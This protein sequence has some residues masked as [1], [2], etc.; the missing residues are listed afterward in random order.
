MDKRIFLISFIICLII[1]LVHIKIVGSVV[2]GDGRYYYSIAKSLAFDQ[3]FNFE[4]EFELF[5]INEWT[6]NTGLL[7]NK[8][9][10]GP[11]LILLPFLFVTGVFH[12]ALETTFTCNQLGELQIYQIFSGIINIVVVFA[13]L[14]FLYCTLAKYYSSK[15]ARSATLFTLFATNLFFYTSF[16]PVNSHAA[17]FF[18]A[19]VLFF[20][21][22]TQKQNLIKWLFAGISLGW[23]A[24]SR[25]IDGLLIIPAVYFFMQEN[26]RMRKGIL[27]TT[28]FV[29]IF[30]IQI[31]FWL[32]IYGTFLSPYLD[33]N[34]G[35]S[36][37]NPQLSRLLLNQNTGL[38]LWTPFVFLGFL[39]LFK[40]K[41]KFIKIFI[42]TILIMFYFISSWS[43]WDQGGSFGIRMLI[44]C[45][46]MIS[47]G[48]AEIFKR[49]KWKKY[50]NLNPHQVIFVS[51][52]VNIIFIIIYL[53][54]H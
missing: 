46:P 16:D 18:F 42:V 23:I 15:V 43:S 11:A 36:F 10:P 33:G 40:V 31:I 5:S 19:S 45:L 30:T 24:I 14:Y 20:I 7:V 37:F 48:F 53:L 32:T 22:L 28:G 44:S 41:E 54:T 47:F 50:I 2:W 1:F 17:S 26:D 12:C 21:L 39:G 52:T 6:S 27:F 38:L 29:S 49:E 51:A 3:D 4:N 8:Y 35:F 9:P 25:T 34:E 13:G